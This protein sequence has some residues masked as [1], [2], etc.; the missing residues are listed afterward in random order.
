MHDSR[1]LLVALAVIVCGVTLWWLAVCLSG[2][3]IFP[4][5]WQVVLGMV[6]LAQLPLLCADR[7]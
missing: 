6:Q 5:P 4:T 1:R 7:T 2:S 3:L